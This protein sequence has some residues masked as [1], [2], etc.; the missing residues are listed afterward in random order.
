MTVVAGEPTDV[1]LST[2]VEVLS[3]FVNPKEVTDGVPEQ[4]EITMTA[5]TKS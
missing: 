2:K 5:F 3:E 4:V 1:Q